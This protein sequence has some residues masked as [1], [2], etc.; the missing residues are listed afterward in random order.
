MRKIITI[1]I[2]VMGLCIA[3]QTE[4]FAQEKA[5][6]VPVY[7]TQGNGGKDMQRPAEDKP[8]PKTA[9]RGS[10]HL[11]LDNYTGY[12]LDVWVEDIYQGVLAPYATSVRIDVWTPGNYTHW[13]VRTTGGTYSWSNDSYCNDH[14]VF[15]LNIK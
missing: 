2:A 10:C 9:K 3:L 7:A 5:K 14:R 13:Y 12:Y 6:K 11:Y 4:S 8:R 15:T 1:T